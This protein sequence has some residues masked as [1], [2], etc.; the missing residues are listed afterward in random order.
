MFRTTGASEKTFQLSDITLTGSTYMADWIGFVDPVSS[1]LDGSKAVTYYS[2]AESIADYGVADYAGWY[3]ISEAD[4]GSV[5][6]PCGTAFLANFT[7]PNVTVTYAGE[8]LKGENT[9]NCAGKPAAFVSNLYPGD[10]TMSQITLTG[11]TYMADWIGFVDATSS[12]VDGSRSITYYSAAE[13]IA[14]YG[15]ASY[16]G[17]YDITEA[18][19]GSV[20]LA[21]GDGF[22]CNFTSPSV[23]ITFPTALAE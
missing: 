7:S 11:S 6:Y 15:N 13:S 8:V 3:D 16:A 10:I 12:A 17:W 22:L 14:D 4:K 2:A 20:P 18:D 1:A 23:T 9:V 21:A 5:A 19:K